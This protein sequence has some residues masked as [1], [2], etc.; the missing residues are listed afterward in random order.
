MKKKTLTALGVAMIL[1]LSII[2]ASSTFAQTTTTRQD[3]M[4]SIV[5]KIAAKFNLNKADVQ[6]V[7]DEN[8]KEHTAQMKA[9]FGTQLSTYVTEG[10]ITEAQKK[11][12]TEKRAELDAARGMQKDSSQTLTPEKRRAQMEA[13]RT[14]IETWAK[15]NGID[16]QYLSPKGGRGHGGFGHLTRSATQ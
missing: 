12:I 10:K 16:M 15:D 1:G 4:S 3:P 9:N 5:E 13:K 11:L 14:E 6:T 2:G 8:R 7:F